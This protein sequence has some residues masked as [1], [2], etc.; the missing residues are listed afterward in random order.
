V[1]L[2]EKRKT[3]LKAQDQGWNS[4]DRTLT[5]QDQVPEFN[6]QNISKQKQGRK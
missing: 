6:S 4:S 5:Y 1:S 3:K 2:Y